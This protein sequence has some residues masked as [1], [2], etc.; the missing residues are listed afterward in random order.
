MADNNIKV[1]LGFPEHGWMELA[2]THKEQEFR[3]DVSDALSDLLEDLVSAILK[4]TKGIDDVT[5]TLFEEPS[6]CDMRFCRAANLVD[7]TITRYLDGSRASNAGSVEFEFHGRYADLCNAF[8]RA[9]RNLEAR[10]GD[11]NL[12]SVWSYPFPTTALHR[13]TEQIRDLKS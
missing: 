5:V 12:E 11:W 6:I 7:L 3:S 8:W 13:L 10:A 2:I 4:L 9:F 1:E